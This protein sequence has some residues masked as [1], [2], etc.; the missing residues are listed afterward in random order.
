M[1]KL[2]LMER[3]IPMRQ[4][5]APAALF[6]LFMLFLAS[7]VSWYGFQ[8]TAAVVFVAAKYF[9]LLLLLMV[10]ASLIVIEFKF[11]TRLPFSAGIQKPIRVRQPGLLPIL[12]AALT[13]VMRFLELGL[14]TKIK[15]TKIKST[16]TESYFIPPAPPTFGLVQ[17]F[18][19]PRYTTTRFFRL[20]PHT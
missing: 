7:P 18:L 15:S 8:D 20:S 17:F 4:T 10:I 2:D 1:N 13:S 16:S 6:F 5:A 19:T 9:V 11:K 3:D 12:Q 14:S